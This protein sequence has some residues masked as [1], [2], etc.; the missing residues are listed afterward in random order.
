MLNAY[1]FEPGELIINEEE[2][3]K[4]QTQRINKIKGEKKAQLIKNI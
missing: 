2:S 4:E 1:Q 3:E